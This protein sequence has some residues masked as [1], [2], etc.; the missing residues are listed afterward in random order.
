MNLFD[1]WKMWTLHS[2]CNSS[3]C[4]ALLLNWTCYVCI[5]RYKYA[6]IVYYLATNFIW[7]GSIVKKMK[8]S[9]GW[10]ENIRIRC[11]FFVCNLNWLHCIMFNFNKTSLNM[12]RNNAR[13][14]RSKWVH[15]MEQYWK[16]N[17]TLETSL[18]AYCTHIIF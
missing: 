11:F 16:D 18:Y 2:I 8:I 4:D 10:R 9:S 7:F 15:S 5:I 13:N 17:K 3:S 14:E 1:E 6:C 12:N